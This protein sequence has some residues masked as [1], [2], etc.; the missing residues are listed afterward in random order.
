MRAATMGLSLVLMCGLA[1]QSCAAVAG[2]A[3]LASDATAGAGGLG[4]IAA[5]LWLVGAALVLQKPCVSMW[6]FAASVPAC[7]LGG[8]LGFGELFIWS[9]P[10]ALF[11]LGS[12]K[13]IDEVK[14]PPPP[15]APEL[16][17]GGWHPDPWGVARLRY[18]D[19]RAWTAHTSE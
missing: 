10:A 4:L 12:W 1:L 3:L 15:P 18:Y 14:E 9:V 17:P 13:G 16:P 2:G 8:A 7:L 11:A 19:G 5:F 6:L